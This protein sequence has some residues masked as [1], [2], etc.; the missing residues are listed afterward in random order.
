VADRMELMVPADR[1]EAMLEKI[2]KDKGHTLAAFDFQD[3]ARNYLGITLPELEAVN[4]ESASDLEHL[5]TQMDE[6][7]QVGQQQMTHSISV[8]YPVSEQI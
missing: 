6:V 5:T 4:L 2:M 8:N 7:E 3:T 1:M